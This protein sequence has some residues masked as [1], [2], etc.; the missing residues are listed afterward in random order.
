MSSA[1]A[2]TAAAIRAR[3]A[4]LFGGAHSGLLVVYDNEP[5]VEPSPELPYVALKI[6]WAEATQVGIPRLMRDVGLVL[7]SVYVPQGTGEGAALDLAD[8]ART[9]FESVSIAIN[10]NLN[11]LFLQPRVQKVG[12]EG[13]YYRV[14]V[15]GRFK[16]D[17]TAP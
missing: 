12:P 7:V 14:N 16:A 13:P 15:I 4:T 8:A 11:L 9:V 3:F 1:I 10:S 17:F 6:D 2:D 5:N